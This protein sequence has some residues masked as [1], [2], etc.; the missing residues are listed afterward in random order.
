[1]IQPGRQ[2]TLSYQLTNNSEKN[3]EITPSLK[4]LSPVGENGLIAFSQIDKNNPISLSFES[5]EKFG[6]PFPLAIGETKQLVV[7]LIVDKNAPEKDYYSTL[8]FST[9]NLD[10]SG[11][12]QTSSISQ[13]GS[14]ML[15]SISQSGEPILSGLAKLEQL[16]KIIDSFSPLSLNLLI[17]NTGNTLFKPFGKV[18][19][20]G[21]LHQKKEEKI[22][23]QNVL[24]GSSRRFVVTPIKLDLPLGKL[25]VKTEFQ[26]NQSPPTI[27]NS[28]TL[29]YLPYKLIGITILIVAAIK[30]IRN[31]KIFNRNQQ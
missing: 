13:I 26:P 14:N 17:T 18:T 30:T 12:N 27:E 5:G 9:G 4:K 21:W 23:E 20:T 16:P 25:T 29:F 24:A 28:V 7:K 6:L 2:L 1:M 22:L 10:S 8:L 19:V 15:I 3:L 31:K 11:N